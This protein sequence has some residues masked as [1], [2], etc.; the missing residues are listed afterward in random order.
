MILIIAMAGSLGS[1]IHTFRSAIKYIGQQDFKRSWLAFYILLPYIGG[2]LGLIFYFVIRGGFFA[3][4]TTVQQTNPFGFAALSGLVGLF[5]EQAVSKL[6]AVFEQLLTK[7]EPGKDHYKESKEKK[8]QEDAG[9]TNNKKTS[10][11][12]DGAK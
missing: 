6:K 12:G 10:E 3:A 2:V 7:V 4:Q 5:S 1:L 11:D 9:K 8:V